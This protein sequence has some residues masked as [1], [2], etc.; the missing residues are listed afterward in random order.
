MNCIW[1]TR[2]CNRSIPRSAHGTL[3][4]GRKAKTATK[5]TVS[6]H[7][8]YFSY[9]L[10]RLFFFTKMDTANIYSKGSRRTSKT[11]TIALLR[12]RKQILSKSTRNTRLSRLVGNTFQL[13]RR[14]TTSC[15]LSRLLKM[16][17]N[18]LLCPAANCQCVTLEFTLS[19][20]LTMLR[21]PRSFRMTP[22]QL[23]H[24]SLT[25]LRAPTYCPFRTS[26]FHSH[27]HPPP[28]AALGQP[29]LSFQILMQ[30]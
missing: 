1:D 10:I 28:P 23:L 7:V 8:S 27:I 26:Y 9:S 25:S 2:S 15:T 29:H 6:L 13:S 19:L 5:R 17:Y 16:R 3:S 14:S 4:Y 12:R 24:Q 11:S 21:L 20:A 18:F 22:I 30:T